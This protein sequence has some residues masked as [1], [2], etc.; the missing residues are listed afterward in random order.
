MGGWRDTKPVQ[1][2]DQSKM[3]RKKVAIKPWFG[4]NVQ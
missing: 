4:F 3:F 2:I 1:G